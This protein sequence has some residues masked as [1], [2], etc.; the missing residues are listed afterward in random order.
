[1]KSAICDYISAVSSIIRIDEQES[2]FTT[3]VNLAEFQEMIEEINRAPD[4]F[5]SAED[6][7]EKVL[8]NRNIYNMY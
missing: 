8:D 5:F 1:M 4:T 2:I 7:S 3:H 6:V